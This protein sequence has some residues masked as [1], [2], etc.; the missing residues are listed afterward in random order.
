VLLK[1]ARLQEMVN[2]YAGMLGSVPL[3]VTRITVG[4]GFYVTGKGKLSHIDGV[5]EFFR[6]LHIPFPEYQ[7]P[8]VARLEY[9]GGILLM[10]GLFTRP[11]AALLI[12][13]MLVAIYTSDWEDLVKAWD[14]NSDTFPPVTVTAYTYLVMLSFLACY[15]AGV[16]S[17]DRIGSWLLQKKAREDN[18]DVGMRA[19]GQ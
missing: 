7:A 19:E 5:I 1:I 15:G 14:V 13:T 8:F 17:L 18:P 16:F 4:L 11:T 3:L 10:L 2:R 6:S 9:F 12:S